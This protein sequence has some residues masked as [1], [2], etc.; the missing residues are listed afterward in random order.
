[1]ASY[2]DPV[3]FLAAVGDSGSIESLIGGAGVAGVWLLAI[4]GG[5]MHPDS[6]MKRERERAD[7]AEARVDELT[8]VYV[9]EVIPAL[10]A[11]AS[12]VV[13]VASNGTP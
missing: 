6:S 1:M 10:N 9:K 5:K 3:N 13:G 2:S 8:D 4:M 7:R 11:A 12:A